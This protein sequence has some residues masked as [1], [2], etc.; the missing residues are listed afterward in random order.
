MRRHGE[1]ADRADT[2]RAAKPRLQVRQE[3]AGPHFMAGD[4]MLEA[5]RHAAGPG[6]RASHSCG[7]ALL[8]EAVMKNEASQ[9]RK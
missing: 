7:P 2:K 6:V 5:T 8:S 4:E 9:S 3:T 1:R